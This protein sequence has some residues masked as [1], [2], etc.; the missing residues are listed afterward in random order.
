MTKRDPHL[1]LQAAPF[2]RRGITTPGLMMDVLLGLAPLVLA[3]IYFFGLSAVLVLLTCTIGAVATEWALSPA[4]P[5]GSSIK[6]GSAILTGI[7][8]GLCLPPAI[9][10]WMAF[11]GGVA[12]IGLGKLMFGGLGQ[13]LFNP[14]LVGRAFLQAAFPTAIT[15]WSQQGTITEF[16]GLR[17]SSWYVPFTHW[18]PDWLRILLEGV[19]GPQVDVISSATPLAFIKFGGEAAPFN[20][21]L[22]GNTAGSLGETCALLII[23]CGIILAFRRTFDWRIP[24]SILLTVAAASGIVWLF[25]HDSPSPLYMLLSGGLLFGAVYMATDPVTSPIAPRGAWIFG[26]G[27]GLIVVLIRLWG[28]LPEGVMYA[29]L[30]MNAATPLIDRIA[31]PRA[32]GR[33]I[34]GEVSA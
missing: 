16:W 24:V 28:G 31:Q 1:L 23:I 17:L 21:L 12:A 15:T 10:L 26:I 8:L 3:A 9:P 18:V 32:F 22:L 5:R 29:I 33:T 20:N 25:N 6:D 27:V 2:L 7:I 19:F 13:N 30:L 34:T 11:L 4:R 14:A